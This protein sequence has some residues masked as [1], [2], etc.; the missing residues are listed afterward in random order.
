[1]AGRAKVAERAPDAGPDANDAGMRTRQLWLTF[2]IV[3]LAVWT[4]WEFLAPLAWAAVLG[5]AEWPLYRRALRRFPKHPNLI[6]LGF[7]LATALFVIGPLS[8]AA[9]TLAQES[10]GAIDWF[11]RVQQT[12][13]PAPAWLSGIPFAGDRVASWWQQHLADPRGAS[14]MLGSISAG[15]ILAWMRSIPASSR[16]T[17]A[18]SQSP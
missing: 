16:A 6:A 12:G 14:A 17:P 8:L 3:A 11:Q 10:Q 7:T 2:A 5:M 18:Y 9:V 1:M 13:L 4:A 15:S